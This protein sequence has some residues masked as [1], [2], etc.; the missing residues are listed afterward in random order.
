MNRKPVMLYLA[1]FVLAAPVMATAAIK[2]TQLSEN[3]IRISYDADELNSHDGRVELELQIQTAARKIC[4]PWS[5]AQNGSAQHVK[6]GRACYLEAVK[7]AAR[8][9]DG[10]RITSR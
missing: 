8:T 5:Y 4:G 1:C 6:Q 10:P 3:E 2:T 7:N 9:V